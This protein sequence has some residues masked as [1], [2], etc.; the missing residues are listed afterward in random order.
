MKITLDLPDET[1]CVGVFINYFPDRNLTTADALILPSK[2][3]KI[4]LYADGTQEFFDKFG[5]LDY[6]LHPTRTVKS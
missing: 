6:T 2:H 5:E 3:R 1:T 4:R